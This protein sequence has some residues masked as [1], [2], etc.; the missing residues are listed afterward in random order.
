MVG[1]DVK[2]QTYTADTITL[3]SSSF[4]ISDPNSLWK[5]NNLHDLY[6]SAHT[7][8]IALDYKKANDLGLIC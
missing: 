8:G 7:P 3:M 5:G 2:L 1:A 6:D 4:E